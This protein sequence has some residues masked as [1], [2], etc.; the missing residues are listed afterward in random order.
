MMSFK[1]TES[2]YDRAQVDAYIAHLAE[3][4]NKMYDS[5]CQLEKRCAELTSDNQNLTA[6]Y[7]RQAQDIRDL[8]TRPPNPDVSVIGKVLVDAQKTAEDI[9]AKAKSKA[10]GIIIDA[11]I[12]TRAAEI[13]KQEAVKAVENIYHTI[14]DITITLGGEP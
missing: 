5:H 14:K 12:S 8:Q 4:Y 6:S 3:S 10:D 1:I 7:H 9:I 2:G 13:K 11:Q